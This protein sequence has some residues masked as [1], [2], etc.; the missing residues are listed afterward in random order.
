MQ[1]LG[2]LLHVIPAK[3]GTSQLSF[4]KKPYYE[5]PGQAGH[6]DAVGFILAFFKCDSAT[7]EED[8]GKIAD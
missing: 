6:D 4:L 7:S 2:N 3:A 1:G 8:K 5:M